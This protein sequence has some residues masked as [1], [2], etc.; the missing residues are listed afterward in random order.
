MSV[1]MQIFFHSIM[2]KTLGVVIF[3]IEY[4]AMQAMN[5]WAERLSGLF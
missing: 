4:G 2:G 5:A 3:A 1:T